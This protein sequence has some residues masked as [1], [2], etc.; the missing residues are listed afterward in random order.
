MLLT[1]ENG[2]RS[3]F[4]PDAM[5]ASLQ[6]I[7]KDIAPSAHARSRVTQG[8]A[9]QLRQKKLLSLKPEWDTYGREPRSF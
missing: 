5:V 8:L 1:C 4:V 7:R 9:V 6:T 2:D 3:G